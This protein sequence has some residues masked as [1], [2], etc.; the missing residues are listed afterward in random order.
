MQKMH[1]TIAFQNEVLL[2]KT[3]HI[4]Y[5]NLKK[6]HIFSPSLML[7][8][9]CQAEAWWIFQQFWGQKLCFIFTYSMLND[10]FVYL[11]F[12]GLQCMENKFNLISLKHYF[13]YLNWIGMAADKSYSSPLL[14]Y[15]RK[16]TY[17]HWQLLCTWLWLFWRNCWSSRLFW[18]PHSPVLQ[19]VRLYSPILHKDQ[20]KQD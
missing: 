15:K 2:L 8:I 13:I 19:Q 18:W 3:F 4:L 7:K 12:S 9:L 10:S 17:L 20:G 16:K 11:R 14:T 1:G 5:K 6:Y